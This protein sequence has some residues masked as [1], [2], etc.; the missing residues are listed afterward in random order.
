MDGEGAGMLDQLPEDVQNNLYQDFL[1]KQFLEDFKY[2]FRFKKK[3]S[4]VLEEDWNRG[5]YFYTWDDEIYRNFM[6]GLL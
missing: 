2:I 5:N 1:Y 4:E 3:K 6:V